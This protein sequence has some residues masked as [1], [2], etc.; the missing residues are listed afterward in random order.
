MGTH[1]Y[2]SLDGGRSMQDITS[3]VAGAAGIDVG[4]HAAVPIYTDQGLLLG[5]DNGLIAVSQGDVRVSGGWA[6]LTKLP[7]AVLSLSVAGRA[8]SSVIH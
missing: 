2:H 4:S 1:I 3:A 5:F 6:P 7:G 8:P